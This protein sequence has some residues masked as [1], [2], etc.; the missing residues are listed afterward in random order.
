MGIERLVEL[1]YQAPPPL[2]YILIRY[3]A[4]TFVNC[5]SDGQRSDLHSYILHEMRETGGSKKR[6]VPY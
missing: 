3:L 6:R 2:Q 5:A 4:E 1:Y